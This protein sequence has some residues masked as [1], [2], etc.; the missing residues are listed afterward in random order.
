MK[1]TTRTYFIAP[2]IYIQWL[3][4]IYNGKESE[5]VYIDT[6]TYIYITV[7]FFCTPET[8]TTLWIN[9]SLIKG[10]KRNFKIYTNISLSVDVIIAFHSKAQI[11]FPLCVYDLCPVGSYCKFLNIQKEFSFTDTLKQ[12]TSHC[13]LKSISLI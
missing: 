9:Y 7:S 1:Q 5:K 4:M 12:N 6:H 11:F 3:V 10:L 8:N 13:L 2:G